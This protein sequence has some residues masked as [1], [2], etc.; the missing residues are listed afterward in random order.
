MSVRF[1]SNERQAKKMYVATI[2]M[3]ND[4]TAMAFNVNSLDEELNIVNE[5]CI[6]GVAG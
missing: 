3:S 1:F 2:G 6:F 5:L 4:A